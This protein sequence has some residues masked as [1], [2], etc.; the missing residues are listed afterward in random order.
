MTIGT[1]GAVVGLVNTTDRVNEG[2]VITMCAELMSIEEEL[3]RP[4][5][6]IMEI[7]DGTANCML[8]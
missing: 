2:S 1:T 7:Y 3:R 6:V 5:S 8:L 4:L